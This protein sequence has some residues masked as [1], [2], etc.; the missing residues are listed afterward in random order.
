MRVYDFVVISRKGQCRHKGVD[1][2]GPERKVLLV[3]V[4]TI[5]P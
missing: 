3:V 5:V 1:V 2:N 4:E